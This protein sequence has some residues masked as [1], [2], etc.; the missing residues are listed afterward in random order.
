MK[1]F[2]ICLMAV[3]LTL[4]IVPARSYATTVE[5]PA[6]TKP[7]ENT[8]ESAEAKALVLR[9]NEIKS[10]DKSK[11]KAKDKKALHK[12]VRTIKRKLKDISGGVYLSAGTIIIILLLLILL[13]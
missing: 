9:L 10:L 7:I 1:K 13:T 2:I 4:T 3:I 6:T 8:A 12:E 5:S 11:L